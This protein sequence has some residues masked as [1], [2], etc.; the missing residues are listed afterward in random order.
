MILFFFNTIRNSEKRC[1]CVLLV[2][3]DISIKSRTHNFLFVFDCGGH[4]RY[5]QILTLRGFSMADVIEAYSSIGNSQWNNITSSQL[6]SPREQSL[7]KI[8]FMMSLRMRLF[9]C[10]LEN[11]LHKFFK[12][13]F[14]TNTSSSFRSFILAFMYVNASLVSVREELKTDLMCRQK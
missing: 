2:A 3:S 12:S 8:S 10:S 13:D 5:E 1:S 6:H 14:V 9:S 7:K 11:R 4:G